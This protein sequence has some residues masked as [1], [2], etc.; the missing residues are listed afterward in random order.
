MHKL[1]D[2]VYQLP[3]I[4]RYLNTYLIETEDGL[5]LIDTG[6]TAAAVNAISRQ[7]EAAGRSL[8]D[9]RHVFI[10]HAHA[11]HVGGLPELQKRINARTY[12]HHREAMIVRGEAKIALPAPQELPFPVGLVRR[13]ISETV[14]PARV[15]TEVKQG[16]SIAGEFLVVEL[17]G[18]AFGHC[19]LWWEQHRVLVGGDVM[20]NLPWGLSR[21]LRPATPDMA[22]AV[23]SIKQ[24][25]AMDVHTLCICHGVPLV[26]NAA[27]TIRSFA[28]RL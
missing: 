19:G 27:P 15:D 20:M 28:A 4:S 2:R 12:A 25:A 21:P 18:H 14:E 6:L 9:I 13:S 3:L 23:R 7:L 17:P 22:T 16:D 5:L 1:L 10:T 8:D 11:D 26:G 24:V